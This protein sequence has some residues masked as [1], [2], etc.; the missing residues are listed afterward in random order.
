VKLAPHLPADPKEKNATGE[1]QPGYLEQLRCCAGACNPKS[2]RSK[3]AD[4]DRALSLLGRQA[5][6][7]KANH[8]GI[9]SSQHQVDHD[10]LNQ[11]RDSGAG[12]DIGH[13]ASLRQDP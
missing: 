11:G 12:D 4:Y 1:R 8:D 9:V 2:S 13:D 5:C 10:D 6:R 3:D 7:G